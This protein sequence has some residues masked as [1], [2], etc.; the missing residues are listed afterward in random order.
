MTDAPRFFCEIVDIRTRRV[1]ERRGP[2]DAALAEAESGRVKAPA[3]AAR[4]V[5]EHAKSC[6]LLDPAAEPPVCDCGAGR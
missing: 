2:F 5:V 4:R 6:A 3:H 1:I